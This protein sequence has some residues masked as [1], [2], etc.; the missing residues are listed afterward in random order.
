MQYFSRRSFIKVSALSACSLFIS[1]T[2][3]GCGD[4]NDDDKNYISVRFDHGVASGD[5]LSDRVIIWTRAT[6]QEEVGAQEQISIDFE[7]AK[8]SAFSDIVRS[9]SVTTSKITDFTI[10]IDVQELESGTEYYYRFK[11]KESVS[12]I[13][14][15]K[16][17]PVGEIATVKMALFTCAN[18]TNGYFNAYSEAAKIE[19]LDVSVHVGDYIYE[20]GMFESDGQTP[21]YATENAVAINRVLP[22]DNDQELL[23]LEDYRKRYA[24]YHTDSG[25]QAIHQA[26]AMIVV[27]DDHEVANDTYKGGAENHNENEGDFEA[28]TESALQAYFEW[29]PIRPIEDKKK[30]YRTF[31]F[32]NLVSLHML[33]TRLF[34]R[35]K[36]LNYADYYTP[37]FDVGAFQTDVL[38]TE[39]TMLGSEQV[40]WLQQQLQTSTATWQVL[41]Q[42]V[43]MGK[44]NL[45]AEILTP[46]AQLES[47]TA[48]EKAVLLTQINTSLAQL[49][50]IKMKAA[51]NVALTE[52]EQARL[53]MVLPYNLDAWDGYFAEREVIL[54]VAKALDKNL[55]VLAG[56]THNAW[57]SDLKDVNGDVVGVEFAT[58]SVT[59]PGLEQYL[60]LPDQ[61]SAMGFEGALQI[62]V[63]DLHYVNSY[64]RGFMTVTFT[65]T[66]AI[67]EWHF[68][69]N[70]QSSTYGLLS[71]RSKQL[72]V[73]AGN[74][75]RKVESV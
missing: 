34:G 22:E 8:D 71:S 58:S 13:G 15:T 31:D 39:R 35:D 48:E 38:D 25:T 68:V 53:A 14:K 5:P 69:D 67:S 43:L 63:D 41:G 20:Y 73:V 47:A 23:T 64:D 6:P 40:T 62:L 4:D 75:G 61:A 55:V 66:Q 12:T 72:K 46:V 33:E 36:Q 51:Q 65:P 29:L 18:Y 21:A 49:V 9:E 52:I 57:A 28:R 56:D 32:G 45:P 42:Q 37:E 11:S 1:T 17:L 30:I 19:D 27:W 60:G 10:K 7:V 16:T 54:G 3:S 50:E 2:F 74:E 44:M 24:L 26:A 70:Y 59:S